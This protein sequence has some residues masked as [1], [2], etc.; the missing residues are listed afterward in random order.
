ML[1]ADTLHS[2]TVRLQSHYQR[3]SRRLIP[4]QQPTPPRPRPLP[5]RLVMMDSTSV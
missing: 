2:L 1:F 4:P 3:P 5:P